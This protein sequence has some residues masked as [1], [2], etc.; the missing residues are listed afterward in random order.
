[1]PTVADLG[2][3]AKQKW[4]GAYDQLSDAALGAKVKAKYP[5]A[6]DNFVDA[7]PEGTL[8][9]AGHDLSLGWRA[10]AAHLANT[11][12]NVAGFI[13]GTG[14][15]AQ[16]LHAYA[17]TEA[18]T[19]QET[20][21]RDGVI[22]QIVQGIGSA[23]AS[24]AEYA[25][26]MLAKRYAPL[27]AG[28]IGAAG[29][30]DKGGYEALTEGAKAAGNFYLMGKAAGLPTRAA[31]IVG[32][33]TAQAVP[34]ALEGGNTKQ[35]IAQ[36]ITGGVLGG[37]EGKARPKEAT[38]PNEALESLQKDLR[39]TFSPHSLGD[40]AAETKRIIIPHAAERARRADIADFALRE[41][42]KE[43]DK[44]PVDPNNP[45]GIHPKAL[46]FID[47]IETGNVGKIDPRLQPFAKEIRK[48]F[49]ERLNR[50][51]GHGLLAQYV[52]NYF[53]HLFE[54]PEAAQKALSILS[55]RPLEGGKGFLRQRKLATVKEAMEFSKQNPQF[56]LK[57]V[58]TNP[59]D[60]ALLQLREQDKFLTAR[61]I[62][63][64]MK[65]Q[66][67]LKYVRANERAPAGYTKINDKFSTVM[68]RTPQSLEIMGYYYA[69]E[70][71]AKVMNNY[72]S[73]GLREKPWFRKFL[74][75]ANS[76][77]MFQ[78]GYSA[79]H[80]GFTTS[81]AAISQFS[82]ALERGI[83][84][85]RTGNR[86]MVRGAL[87]DAA[88]SATVPFEWATGLMN[89]NKSNML[90]E[91]WYKPGTHP[92]LSK[93]VDMMK[94]AGARVQ[95][96]PFYRLDAYRKMRD[97]FRAGNHLTALFHGGTYAFERPM[98]WM[99]E[100]VVPMQK[101]GAF[102][103][104]A[105]F[106]LEKLGPNAGEAQ[107]RESMQKSWQSIDNRF[108]QMV[109][110]NQ[111]WDK[112]AKDLLMA[113]VR[114]VGWNYGTW[115]ELGGGVG[116]LVSAVRAGTEGRKVQVT[117]RMAYLAAMP[118]I[119]GMIGAL[120]NYLMTGKAAHGR[121]Y[122]YPQTGEL[123]E[124]GHPR[125]LSLPSY[126]REAWNVAPSAGESGTGYAKRM[127]RMVQGKM[128]PLLTT[129]AE[130]LENQ[131][132]RGE[133][134]RHADDPGMKQLIDSAK[135]IG[136]QVIPFAMKY[137][138]QDP[139]RRKEAFGGHSRQFSNADSVRAFF[140]MTP[141]PADIEKRP[142][143]RAEQEKL[144]ASGRARTQAQ[145]ARTDRIREIEKA[146]RLH[147]DAEARRLVKEGLNRGE[148]TEKDRK[149][150]EKNYRVPPGVQHFKS[151]GLV[152]ALNVYFN[153]VNSDRT[154][155]QEERR[156][157]HDVLAG[158]VLKGWARLEARPDGDRDKLKARQQ[159]KLLN[160]M[161]ANGE[162][163]AEISAQPDTGDAPDL[164][165]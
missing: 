92:Q 52:D 8:A 18:P 137:T 146:L 75:A 47:H 65:D 33:A 22:S 32:A 1:M 145:Y 150:I 55:K 126:M 149:Q 138:I 54:R 61:D 125:R 13:P 140:G 51:Q 6:Y 106:E 105:E 71:A 26:A 20:Q 95:M 161:D 143:E 164:E 2:K 109:Y 49:D 90:M 35:V 135:Y 157:L 113:S 102:H 80:L 62:L 96:D 43:F 108:G 121:D 118:V 60:I 162:I 147:E 46:E 14:N 124:Y 44:L 28:A 151:L 24:I 159:L 81:E 29:A 93:M 39:G 45:G 69:P 84:G 37:L 86:G 152:D 148:I 107:I 70:D 19:P 79:F 83:E 99:F 48:A 104:L 59:I 9:S 120:T 110:D 91:E 4:P 63:K 7:P 50:I 132:W 53:P 122:W 87:K 133:E 136:D 100:Y 160:M 128:N 40:N 15:A 156:Q 74:G 21:D 73:P 34:T 27:V 134:I 127:G 68:R 111:F 85:A 89:K 3:L 97:A 112:T 78:L 72:L 38:K 17:K 139:L 11:A 129:I 30:A 5:G 131:D 117:H 23:P 67:L 77:N 41:A 76:M 16:R 31:R 141:A 154:I 123:D 153:Y 10:G 94:Q 12:G 58:S 64:E 82:L 155:P 163:T 119:T 101:L 144:P 114:S 66:G 25:P 130:M 88:K 103:R 36:A 98:K 158:K 57:L 165:Q 56:G 142:Y 116:D 115:A 42:R